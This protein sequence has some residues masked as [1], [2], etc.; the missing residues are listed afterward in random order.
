MLIKITCDD[1]LNIL[2]EIES[3]FKLLKLLF[4]YNFIKV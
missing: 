4:L 2:V 3:I 1:A